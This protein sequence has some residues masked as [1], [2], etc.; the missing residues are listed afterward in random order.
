MSRTSDLTDP[1]VL[2]PSQFAD[3]DN[4]GYGDNVS[5]FRGDSCPFYLMNQQ[6][7]QVTVVL[8]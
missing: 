2:D 8:I 7:I 4:D 6:E 1:F 5:G 3:T